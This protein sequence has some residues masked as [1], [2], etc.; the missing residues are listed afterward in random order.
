MNQKGKFSRKQIEQAYSINL[1]DYYSN[2]REVFGITIDNPDTVDR[3]DG[4][5][6]LE[7]ENG[8]FELQVSITDVSAFIP[9]NSPLDHE[10][11]K[12]V[13]TLYHTNP[14]TPM[15][16]AAIGTNLGSLEENQKRLALTVFIDIA[17]NG[18]VRSSK[19]EETLFTN[20][21]AF[22]Y[23]EVEDI[24]TNSGDRP[25]NQLLV[26]MQSLAKILGINR[27]GQSGVLTEFGY[28]DED[29]NLIKDNINTNQLIAEFMILTNTIVAK[30]LH[31]HNSL[32]L[33]RTQDVGIKDLDLAKKLKGHQ[34]VRASYSPVCQSHVGLGLPHYCHFTSPLRR[35]PD[36]INHRIIK[37]LI[38]DNSSPYTSDD[39]INLASHIN[40]FNEENKLQRE[41]YLKKKKQR[42]NEKKF[43]AICD[44]DLQELSSKEFSLLIEYAIEKNFL[45]EILP[46]V[47]KRI[48]ELQPKDFYRLW[49]VGGTDKFCD[50]P[51]INAISVLLIKSQLNGSIV[52]YK[53]EYCQVRKKF[54][55]F[56]YVDGLTTLEAAEDEKKT[57][58]KQKSAL[59]WIQ[60]Y[61]E[62][63]LTNN[64]NPIP[65]NE[66]DHLINLNLSVNPKDSDGQVDNQINWIAVI[67]N[68]CQVNRLPY[69][70]YSFSDINGYFLCEVSLQLEEQKLDAQ[71]Y[72]RRKKEAKMNAASALVNKYQLR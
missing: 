33:F 65:S 27:G 47:E 4:V 51:N 66:L 8:N 69:P 39:L 58:A 1:L 61:L 43:S 10:A 64:P 71:N 31:D 30:K 23:Q 24:L 29:G 46:E 56:C 21:K 67:N 44:L 13:T 55:V 19:I 63:Q 28:V 40:N 6:L 59:A 18:Q 22:S 68:Y 2:R 60:A 52:E 49:F 14:V 37:A 62:N 70:I 45:P 32:A 7:K 57:Q 16:P 34:L 54:F 48:D 20:L 50:C 42:E 11:I 5:W 25:E 9:T 41:H 15:F 12:R 35:L 53:S 38:K 72:G 36:L 26:Q 17:Q 3:D